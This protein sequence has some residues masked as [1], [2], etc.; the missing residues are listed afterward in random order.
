MGYCTTWVPVATILNIRKCRY[1]I[2]YYTT[3]QGMQGSSGAGEGGGGYP[4]RVETGGLPVMGREKAKG[5]M[6]RSDGR[7]PGG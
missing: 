2:S 6:G 1:I 7:K 3:I 5:L 4:V